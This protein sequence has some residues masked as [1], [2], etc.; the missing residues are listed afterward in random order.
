MGQT[1][2]EKII[3]RYCG[4]EKVVPGEYVVVSDFVGP[5]GYSFT[6]MNLIASIQ[7]NLALIGAQLAHPERIILNGDHNTPALKTEDVNLFRDVRERAGRLGVKKIYDKEGIGHVVNIEKGEILPGTLFVHIDPQAALAGGIGAYYTNGGRLGS[8][9][10]EAFALGQ[11]TICVPETLRVEMNGNLPHNVMGRDIWLRV[12]NDIGPAGAFGMIIEFAGTTIDSMSIEQRMNL[13]GNAG[14][15]GA[16]GAILQ[17][18]QVTQEWFRENFGRDVELIRSDEDACF[19]RVIKYD[20]ADFVPMVAYPPDV[21]TSRPASELS[22]VRVDQCVIGTCAGGT[23][24][25]LRIAAGILKGKHISEHVRFLVS[26]VTQRV[27]V[28]ASRA[29]YL[30]DL[31]EAG[32]KIL[33]PTCD[34]CLGVIGPLAAGEV[35]LSQQTLNTPGRSGSPEASIYLASAATIAASALNG[36]ITDPSAY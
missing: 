5:I 30:A 20:A 8:T 32:A 31:A 23:L 24:D 13:C 2:S 3:A 9:V 7:D 28:A 4:K 10:M 29:G 22:D 14:F 21:F 1:I 26:P 15:A 19:A 25:D 36:Y 12:L 18:D 6:G 34:V 16:D 33:P 35:G 27:W 17:S 11:L